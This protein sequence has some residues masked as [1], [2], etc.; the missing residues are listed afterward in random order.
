M[1][2]RQVL[3]KMEHHRYTA[4][5]IINKQGKYVGTITEGDL[6][7]AI[8][9]KYSLNF[10]EAEKMKISQIPRK[11]DN[12]PV[13]ADSKIQDLIEKAVNQ[14]FVPVIDDKETFIGIITRKDIIQ[15]C[16]DELHKK[17]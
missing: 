2:V 4:V 3:E 15:Y 12:A 6:L 1:S 10:R 16:F 14:N 7:W 5:P 13:Y 9:N 17:D 11:M 8:K